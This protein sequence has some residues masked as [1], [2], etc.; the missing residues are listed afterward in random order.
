MKNF[1]KRSAAVVATSGT[2]LALAVAD[3]AITAGITA[4]QGSFDSNWAPV[5][6]FYV[7]IVVVLTAGTMLVRYIRRAK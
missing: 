7:G 6:A 1:L 5:F 3:P 4:A 2:G